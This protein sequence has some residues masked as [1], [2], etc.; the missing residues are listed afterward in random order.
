MSA[1]SSLAFSL[2]CQLLENLSSST[3]QR[4]REKIV[5]AWFQQHDAAIDRKG[6]GGLALL[7][8]FLPE[9]RADRVYGLSRARL[10]DIVAQSQGFGHSCLYELRRLQDG[11]GLDL[12]STI[13]QSL[14]VTDDPTTPIRPM[15]IQDINDTLDRVAASCAFSSP[16]HR[17]AARP[18]S[19]DS[20]TSLVLAFRRMCSVEAKW[21][22]RLLLKDLRPAVMPVPL[23]LCLFHFML[24]ELL[25]ARNTLPD[26]LALLQSATFHQMPANLSGESEKSSKEATWA[27]IKPR[28]GTMVGLPVFE[29]ARSIKH[30]YQLVRHRKVSV[31]RKYDGEY[32]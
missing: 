31:E 26:A 23:T 9:K 14:S 4:L 32:C 29:K 2:V 8:C 12:A 16:S 18:G 13:E 17:G 28:A 24:P 19:I 6:P 21:L 27:E 11:D 5:Q 1:N 20:R 15:T 25:R 30:C 10:E 7:S 22:V 3:S